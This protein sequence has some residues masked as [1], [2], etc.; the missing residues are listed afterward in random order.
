MAARSAEEL[1]Q[2]LD[3]SLAWRRIELHAIKVELERRDPPGSPRM[4]ALARCAVVMLYAHWEGFAREACQAYRDYI[5][6]LRLNYATLSDALIEASLSDLASRMADPSSVT[7]LVELV[8]N[9]SVRARI[10]R[11]MNETRANLNFENLEAM[12][13]RLG[14]STGPFET[15]R[16][17]LDRTLCGT[18]HEVAHGRDSFPTVESVIALHAATL[19]MMESVRDL[20]R[21]AAFDGAFRAS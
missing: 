18:R 2:D 3:Q 16:P 13:S 15:R 5:A 14:L 21:D 6:F 12:L 17:L 10:P 11:K 9:P 20:V 7:H 19:S 8:R 1:S 4:R